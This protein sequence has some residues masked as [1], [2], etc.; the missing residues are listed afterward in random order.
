MHI[1]GSRKKNDPRRDDG[2]RANQARY[3]ASAHDPHAVS[4]HRKKWLCKVLGA[5]GAR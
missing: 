2:Q 3:K 4:V 5:V 1:M